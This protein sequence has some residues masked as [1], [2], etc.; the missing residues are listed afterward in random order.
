M[1]LHHWASVIN[2]K[3]FRMKLGLLSDKFLMDAAV[4]I[5]FFIQLISIALMY[6]YIYLTKARHVFSINTLP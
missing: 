4:L 1:L 6:K 3:L 2:L 5:F